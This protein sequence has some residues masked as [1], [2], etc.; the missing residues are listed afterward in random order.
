M[1]NGKAEVLLNE[2]AF[3][4]QII[5]AL[6]DLTAQHGDLRFFAALPSNLNDNN[7]TIG[8]RQ[9][10]ETGEKEAFIEITPNMSNVLGEL[11]H[12]LGLKEKPASLPSAPT[13][14]PVPTGEIK[15]INNRE[16]IVTSDG[17]TINFR[18]GA[19]GEAIYLY[20][21]DMEKLTEIPTSRMH[22][23]E[24]SQE[25]IDVACIAFNAIKK[26]PSKG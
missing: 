23:T 21:E 7:Y 24:L 19:C 11:E 13:P 20:S 6:V 15:E 25:D 22:I 16:A 8:M 12:L 18:L 4:S 3:V 14:T 2:R 10:K 9:H 17:D 5:A 1:E 26:N